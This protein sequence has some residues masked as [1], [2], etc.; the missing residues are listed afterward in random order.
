[1]DYIEIKGY[2]SIKNARIELRP[3]NILIGANGS[4]KSNFLSFIEFLNHLYE[5]KLTKYIDLNGG[6]DKFWQKA[7]V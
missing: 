6:E 3:I 1:M 5:R 2:K 4:G 7:S